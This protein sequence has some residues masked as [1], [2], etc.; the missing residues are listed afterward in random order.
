M[1]VCHYYLH[2]TKTISCKRYYRDETAEFGEE[3]QGLIVVI[4][5]VVLFRFVQIQRS[6]TDA[7]HVAIN[8]CS[9]WI[10]KVA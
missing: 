10:L 8:R 3:K 2:E 6:R 5:F 9:P 4:F 7:P 1:Y